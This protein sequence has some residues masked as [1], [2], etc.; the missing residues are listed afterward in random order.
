MSRERKGGTA[1]LVIELD[2]ETLATIQRAI[3]SAGDPELTPGIV[4]ARLLE[5]ELTAGALLEAT[6]PRRLH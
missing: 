3:D 1:R 2:R 5:R 4:A 6:Q